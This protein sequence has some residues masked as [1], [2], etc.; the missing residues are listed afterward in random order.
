MQQPSNNT[1]AD[2]RGR[3]SPAAPKRNAA[4]FAMG[5]RL[6]GGE[7]ARWFACVPIGG[8]AAFGLERAAQ[9]GAQ[10]QID[11]GHVS[12]ETLE[13]TLAVCAPAAVFSMVFVWLSGRIAPNGNM[14]LGLLLTLALAMAAGMELMTV[15]ADGVTGAGAGLAA[16]KIGGAL[17]A[18]LG[19]LRFSKTDAA[20]RALFENRIIENW[21]TGIGSGMYLGQG[22]A[23][24]GPSIGERIESAA[25]DAVRTLSVAA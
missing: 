12:T 23:V 22:R 11:A 1:Q 16:A 8:V 21:G 9:A 24:E 2:D 18:C 15:S 6:T 14:K 25:G 19:L 10:W 13:H 20:K 17:V 7:L 5:R 4:K 3:V